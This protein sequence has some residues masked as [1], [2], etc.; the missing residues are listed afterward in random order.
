MLRGGG[1]K[2]SS[3]SPHSCATVYILFISCDIFLLENVDTKKMSTLRL[4]I[5]R[6]CENYF[7][8]LGLYVSL[9]LSKVG[10]NYI[11]PPRGVV[12]VGYTTQAKL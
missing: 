8:P 6:K 1:A 7:L 5:Q 2:S 12:I 11:V 10:K 9:F 3:P 4:Q